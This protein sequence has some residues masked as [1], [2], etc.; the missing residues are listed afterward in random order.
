MNRALKIIGI[1]I[2]VLIVVILVLPFLIN[3]NSFRPRLESELSA[4]LG[5]EVKVGNLGLSIWSGSVSAEDLSISDDPAFSKKPF[6]QAKSLKVGVALIPLIFSKSLQVTDL[7][8]D[9]PQI[10]LLSSP[11]GKWN[12]SSIGGKQKASKDPSPSDSKMDLSVKQLAVRDGSLSTGK[13]NSSKVTTYKNVD[14]TVRDFSYTSQFP[15]ALSADLPGGGNL[16][17]DGQAGPIDATDA[18]ATPVDA[19]INVKH[20]D[21]GA[22]GLAGPDI[23]G[24]ADFDGKLKSDGKVLNSTGTVHAEKLKVAEKGSPAGRPVEVKYAIE[25]NLQKE[26]GTLSQGDIAIGKAVAKLTGTYQT[27]GETTDLNMKLN[28]Q[29]MPVDELEAILPALGV[30]L[31]SGSSL[32]GGTLSTALAIGGTSQ[33]PMIT[34]PIKL[35]DTK[36]SGFNL[37]S[38]LSAISKFTGGG[39]SGSDTSIQN[40]STDMHYAPAGIQTQN[41]NL[42]VPSLGVLTGTGTIGPGGQ[43]DYKMNANLSGGA[44]TGLTQLAGLGGKGGSLPFFIRGT[45]SNP[46]FVPDVQG[47]LSGQFKST[48]PGQSPVN[49]VVDKLGGLFGKKKTK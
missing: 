34:G 14:I 8:L 13:A 31:P 2:A 32:N 21:L 20:L 33:N 16:K 1:V 41:I 49:S 37:G 47:M 18:S 29:G 28:G 24:I 12:F 17:L 19:Q 5:R 36:L 27:H 4:A 11:S 48:T 9:R 26:A 7:T 42:T 39:S 40:F 45:T 25:H 22:S 38:K 6:V 3:V 35:A 44:V 10:T 46:Q 23:A 43:L 30:V 15:F